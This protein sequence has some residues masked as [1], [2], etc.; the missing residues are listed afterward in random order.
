MGKVILIRRVR[1]LGVGYS[2][3][4]PCPVRPPDETM[5]IDIPLLLLTDTWIVDVNEISGAD[6][7]VA[8]LIRTGDLNVALVPWTGC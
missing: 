6:K 1:R 8:L 4:V 2:E 3:Q 7:V 5:V